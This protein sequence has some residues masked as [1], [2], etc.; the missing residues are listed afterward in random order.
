MTEDQL[1]AFR[2]EL[3]ALKSRVSDLE[4]RLSPSLPVPS[5]KFEKFWESYP[6]KVNKTIALRVFNKMPAKLQAEVLEAVTKFAAIWAQAPEDRKQ[7]IPY[8]STW[9]NSQ[10]YA[11]TEDEWRRSAGVKVQR[12]LPGQHKAPPPTFRPIE[13]CKEPW[14]LAVYRAMSSDLRPALPEELVDAY[15]EWRNGK[16]PTPPNNWLAMVDEAMHQAERDAR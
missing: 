1:V 15:M 10:G 9:L 4:A 14:V 12:P 13:G 2:A 7:F 16:A 8:P 5:D 11:L 3:E 6:R